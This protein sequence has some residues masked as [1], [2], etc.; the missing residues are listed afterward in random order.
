MVES[1]VLIMN[2]P[3]VL[4]IYKRIESIQKH[5]D[6]LAKV[7]PEKLYIIADAA[8]A[9][10]D[11]VSDQVEKTR[12]IAEDVS[13]PCEVTRIYATENMGCDRRILSGLN[14]VFSQEQQ[15]I[16]LEDDCIPNPSF[17]EYCDQLL[18]RYRDRADV[19]YISGNHLCPWKEEDS[20]YIFSK[21]G[22]TWGWATWADRWDC[23]KGS[24]E[25]DW[26]E[27]KSNHLIER[28]MGNYHGNAFIRELEEYINQD[29]IPWDYQ[30][31]ARC[32]SA[33]KVMIVPGINLVSNIGFDQNA[34]HTME[35]PGGV[36]MTSYEMQFPLRGPATEKPNR[37]YDLARQREIFHVTIVTR[38]KRRIKKVIKK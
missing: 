26:Q 23:M 24:F 15:A 29:I 18:A 28:Q 37:K 38:I 25:K 1:D 33:G 5:M 16:I 8:P 32:I 10:N 22:D 34:T 6:I 17:F 9:R 14:E 36:D 21:R 4:I 27:I 13:W 11:E 3:V 19:C 12:R 31:H 7:K 2:T 30:W 20:S 35:A